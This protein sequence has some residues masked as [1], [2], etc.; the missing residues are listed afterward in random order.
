MAEEGQKTYTAKQ[1]ATRIG[2]DA[3]HLR[4]F[5][6]DAN[7][8]YTA[9][10]QGGRYEFPE[11]QLP[12]IKKAFDAWNSTKV[13][14]NRPSGQK[15]LHATPAVPLIPSQRTQS[16]TPPKRNMDQGLH[17]NA[18]DGDDLRTRMTGIAARVQKHRLE[19]KGG[20]LV[21]RYPES[22]QMIPPPA[23]GLTIMSNAEVAEHDDW[24]EAQA[25]VLDFTEVEDEPTAADLDALVLEGAD[26]E[27]LDLD[28]IEDDE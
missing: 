15:K 3:K 8:G 22:I 2:T 28:K 7:S 12:I 17:G 18:L 19:A 25:Q 27:V 9:V 24:Q 14:R 10:G 11:D 13:R 16:P 1:V 21:P 23:E 4:K 20:R 26:D 5:F 6:R